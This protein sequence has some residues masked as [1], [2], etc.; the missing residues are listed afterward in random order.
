MSSSF[1]ADVAL[2]AGTV[3]S[4]LSRGAKV[5]A[6]GFGVNR[7]E[8][9]DWFMSKEGFNGSLHEDLAMGVWQKAYE[10]T[11]KFRSA[12]PVVKQLVN[13]YTEEAEKQADRRHLLKQLHLRYNLLSKATKPARGNA[14]ARQASRPSC[15]RQASRQLSPFPKVLS[16]P[17]KAKAKATAE[18][19]QEA[20]SL[21]EWL[22]T[23]AAKANDDLT[24]FQSIPTATAGG[25]L[26]LT[27]AQRRGMQLSRGDTYRPIEGI[28]R[29]LSL[30]Q[31]ENPVSQLSLGGSAVTVA[32]GSEEENERQGAAG[33][34]SPP[35]LGASISAV[36]VSSPAP[37]LNKSLS[38][39]CARLYYPTWTTLRLVLEAQDTPLGSPPGWFSQFLSSSKRFLLHKIRTRTRSYLQMIVALLLGT[40]CGVLHGNSPSQSTVFI[41]YVLFNCIFA[42]LTATGAIT[43]LTHD[44]VEGMLFAHEAANGVRQSAEVTARLL[45][46]LVVFLAPMVVCFTIPMSALATLFPLERMLAVWWCQAYAMSPIGYNINLLFP[47]SSVVFTSSLALILNAFFNG[48]FGLPLKSVPES[49]RLAFVWCMPGY[50]AF[51][52]L[53]YSAVME[54]PQTPMAIILI[55]E[56][57]RAG[58]AS[59]ASEGTNHIIAPYPD[60]EDNWFRFACLRMIVFG[61]VLRITAIL[62]F[63]DIYTA[64]KRFLK[65]YKVQLSGRWKR[66]QS[67]AASSLLVTNE[68]EMSASLSTSL[69]SGSVPVD[70]L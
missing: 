58:A 28:A 27:P 33:E 46:D 57:Q 43:T 67:S 39:R 19:S 4:P 11:Q 56:F 68:V 59:S 31:G 47:K 66:S 32:V 6:I 40:L 7:E 51:M 63:V 1:D 65:P 17:K 34:E 16:F 54:L 36:S 42:T 62:L 12:M 41:F 2:T 18:T 61:T 52:S 8:F 24:H 20:P 9:I 3:I 10:L 69:M 23:A 26:T 21:T 64:M 22:K 70:W 37:Y 45:L 48:L 53:A 5:S 38:Q 50:S 44:G 15:S 14:L 25:M 29:V 35:H 60:S 13:I 55:S 49:G 30:C